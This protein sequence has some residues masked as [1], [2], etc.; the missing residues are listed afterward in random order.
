MKQEKFEKRLQN[1]KAQES[2]LGVEITIHNIID[3]DHLDCTWYGGEVGTIKYPDGF[4]ISIGAYGDIRMNGF[5]NGVEIDVSDKTNGG[6]VYREIGSFINDDQLKQL[7]NADDDACDFIVFRNN[8]WF[9]FNLITPDGRWVD[10]CCL[11]NLIEGDLLSCFE[12]VDEYRN[13]TRWAE[14]NV[15]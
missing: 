8:N 2:E 4:V 6:S 14:D 11:E 10:L 12:N 15:V 5:F 3:K 9:E 7:E 13:A 1:I